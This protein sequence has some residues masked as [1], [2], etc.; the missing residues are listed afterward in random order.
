MGKYQK[1]NQKKSNAAPIAVLIIAVIAL[2][3]CVAVFLPRMGGGQ[4]AQTLPTVPAVTQV[5][6]TAGETSAAE[7]TLP[8]QPG[9]ALPLAL[10]DG[11]LMIQSLFQYDGLNPDCAN[12]E[13]TDIGAITL[14]NISGEY[15]EEAAISLELTDGTKLNFVVSNLPAGKTVMAFSA[16]NT[17]I[18]PDAVCG[19]AECQAVW[20]DAEPMPQEVSASVDGMLI[21]LTNNT[22]QDIPELVVYCRCP[23]DEEY[24]GGV[25]YIYTVNDLP[26]NGTAVVEAWDCILGMAEVVR[27]AINQE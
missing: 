13:A 12:Q 22:A 14:Q 11:R 1:Q 15:L 20:S 9:R 10:E 21:T 6:A 23:L 7:T 19:A 5:E 16:D 27:I 2:V 3:I 18:A 26:A 8:A 24:F 4:D 17:A 25:T